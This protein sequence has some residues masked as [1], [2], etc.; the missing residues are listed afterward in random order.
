MCFLTNIKSLIFIIAV[1]LVA[2]ICLVVLL[3]KEQAMRNE[4]ALSSICW[5]SIAGNYKAELDYSRGVREKREKPES[6]YT[7]DFDVMAQKSYMNSY[8]KKFSSLK[9]QD[10]VQL[11]E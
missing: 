6:T 5:A 9:E 2:N 1:L 7:E 3:I 8:S 4:F 11:E 10:K